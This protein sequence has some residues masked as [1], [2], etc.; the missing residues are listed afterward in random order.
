MPIFVVTAVREPMKVEE[1]IKKLGV[2]HLSVAAGAWLVA[3]DGTSRELADKTGV[4]DGLNGTGLVTSVGSYSG[5]AAP[6]V[7][8]WLKVHWP[9][10]G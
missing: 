5:R 7:W 1:G 2:P 9:K 10:N 3:F 4:R 6:E 8:E